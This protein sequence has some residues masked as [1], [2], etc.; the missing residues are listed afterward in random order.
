[1]LDK[2]VQTWNIFVLIHTHT[3]THK[4]LFLKY[5]DPFFRRGRLGAK[6]FATTPKKK[7]VSPPLEPW[8][9][10]LKSKTHGVAV[11]LRKR[12]CVFLGPRGDGRCRHPPT[13]GEGRVGFWPN[14]LKGGSDQNPT[15]PLLPWVRVCTSH[16]PWVSKKKVSFHFMH[17]FSNVFIFYI[18]SPPH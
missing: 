1:M 15:L 16:L 7:M 17:L 5:F 2:K 18:Y 14:P 13:E 12:Q 8:M 6:I 3:D 10:F 4:F 11:L 9:K